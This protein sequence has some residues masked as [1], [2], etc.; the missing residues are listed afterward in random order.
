MDEYMIGWNE[1]VEFVKTITQ[2]SFS[3]L[4]RPDRMGIERVQNWEPEVEVFVD[5]VSS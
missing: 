5:Q 1:N 3:N 4:K 2:K